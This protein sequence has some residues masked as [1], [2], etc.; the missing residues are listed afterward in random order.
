[1]HN[2]EIHN[3][4]FT[5]FDILQLDDLCSHCDLNLLLIAL[6]TDKLPFELLSSRNH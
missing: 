6:H 2:D 5:L 1:M 4:H 3:V